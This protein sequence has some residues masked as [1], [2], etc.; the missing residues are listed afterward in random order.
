MSGAREWK[1]PTWYRKGCRTFSKN[2][3]VN[4]YHKRPYTNLHCE[5]YFWVYI[6]AIWGK[7]RFVKNYKSS[8]RRICLETP[9]VA[10][11]V[12]LQ[13]MHRWRIPKRARRLQVATKRREEKQKEKI[14]V[15]DSFP[16][17]WLPATEGK[18]SQTLKCSLEASRPCNH[19]RQRRKSVSSRKRRSWGQGVND[20]FRNGFWSSKL[21]ANCLP[22]AC[23]S[24][25]GAL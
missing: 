13:L 18:V 16:K 22:S 25:D 8:F 17:A 1:A 24:W 19:W 10:A 20:Q 2:W 5:F 9:F 21:R 6:G 14:N 4:A 11:V 3:H 7:E 12:Q 15:L 23:G